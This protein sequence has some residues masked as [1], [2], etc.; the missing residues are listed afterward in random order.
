MASFP[1]DSLDIFKKTNFAK[2]DI[3]N[4]IIYS[5]NDTYTK[6]TSFSGQFRYVITCPDL[7]G[8]RITLMLLNFDVLEN[9]YFMVTEVITLYKTTIKTF[10]I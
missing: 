7:V 2:I 4:P 6:I 8:I 9:F 5:I 10:L 3:L 1:G